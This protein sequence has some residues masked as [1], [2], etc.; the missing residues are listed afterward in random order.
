[1]PLMT[2]LY[3]GVSGLNSSQNAINITAHNLANVYTNGYVRQQAQFADQTY[4]KYGNS[5]VNTMQIGYG[6]YNARTQHYR[7]ILLDMAYREQSGREGFYTTQYNAVE[8]IETI[9]G[10]LGKDNAFQKSLQELWSA[11]S[12]VAKT[13]DSIVAR[14]GLI[15][16]T[17][18]FIS[19]SKEIYS[20][21]TNYQQR[22]DEKIRS[23]VDKINSLGD[24]ISRYNLLI[25]GV[26]AP[27]TEQAMDYRDKR[28]A[29]IDE[30]GSMIS[31]SYSEDENGFV[32]IRAGGRRI[33]HKR[34]MFSY[35]CR[36]TE[37]RE[38][39]YLCNTGMA[40]EQ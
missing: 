12:E 6:V 1:M 9:T 3:T 7:D 15:M 16:Y 20:D 19:R 26:E 38:W 24:E 5:S 36:R 39:F 37:C 14:S 32:T 4:T 34:R 22:L 8:E 28:D 40:A 35:G 21:L 2:N 23:N 25:Q 27:G 18:T 13:P 30:L 17:E 11:I 31:I 29:L 33:C 10:E